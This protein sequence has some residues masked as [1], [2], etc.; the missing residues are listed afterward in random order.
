MTTE[1]ITTIP[2]FLNRNRNEVSSPKK[3]S[4]EMR[5]R[6]SQVLSE[7]GTKNRLSDQERNKRCESETADE[8]SQ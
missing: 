8:E 3:L 2:D 1:M 4:K 6:M 5:R 7:K